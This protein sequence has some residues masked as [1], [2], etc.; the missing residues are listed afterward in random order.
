V[1]NDSPADAARE[2]ARK[3][4][5][6][7]YPVRRVRDLAVTHPQAEAFPQFARTGINAAA[8]GLAAPGRA[9]EAVAASVS[10]SFTDGIATERKIFSELM[11]SSES[12]ALRH[13]FFAERAASKVPGLTDK[14]PQRKI[15]RVAV[16][17]AGTMGGGIAMSFVTPAASD[18]A[19]RQTGGSGSRHCRYSQVLR[20]RCRQRQAE[21]GR[22]ETAR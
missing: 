2:F 18:P 19:R 1:T 15:E 7:G 5:K 14:T 10:Q 8:R 16:V 21:G 13:A 9:L 17:G 11:A 3:L 22:G 12:Q 4:G 20:G 6:Q